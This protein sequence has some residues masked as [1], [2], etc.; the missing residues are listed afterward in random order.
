MQLV[1]QPPH[2]QHKALRSFIWTIAPVQHQNP[3]PLVTG[4][5][6]LPSL[7]I[8]SPITLSILK[9]FKSPSKVEFIGSASPTIIPPCKFMKLT[10]YYS[11]FYFSVNIWRYIKINMMFDYLVCLNVNYK[12]RIF[13]G[14]GSIYI[15][16]LKSKN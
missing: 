11:L 16:I 15:S 9:T 1:Q 5:K 14:K 3:F 12:L 4:I 2:H 6:I 7:S 10:N 8:G 13:Q